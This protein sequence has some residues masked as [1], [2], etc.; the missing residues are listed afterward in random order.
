[1]QIKMIGALVALLM[2]T[3]FMPSTGAEHSEDPLDLQKAIEFAN[4]GDVITVH[5]DGS[6]TPLPTSAT[7]DKSGLTICRGAPVDGQTTVVQVH[8]EAT[9]EEVC[10]QGDDQPLPILDASGQGTTMLDIQA[11]GVTVRDL[12][13]RW[14]IDLPADAGTQGNPADLAEELTSTHLVGVNVAAGDVTL[15]RNEIRLKHGPCASAQIN[16]QSPIPAIGINLANGATD[17]SVVDN[18]VEVSLDTDDAAIGGSIG[19]HVAS[20]SYLI[21]GN[22][23]RYWAD[24]AIE[25]T[26]PTGTDVGQVATERIVRGNILDTNPVYGIEVH[27][28][29]ET[30][31]PVIEANTISF[32]TVAPVL[33]QEADEVVVRNNLIQYPLNTAGSGVW[34]R[35][36]EHVTLEDN[37]FKLFQDERGNQPPGAAVTVSSAPAV[38]DSGPVD[39]IVLRGNCFEQGKAGFEHVALKVSSDVQLSTIDARL[40]DWSVD[41]WDEVTARV[42]DQGATNTIQVLPFLTSS[43]ENCAE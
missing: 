32:T 10:E 27:D 38:A 25:I 43:S 7:V 21:E 37:A 14:T 42:L 41:T 29:D 8:H 13:L 22:T 1:M 6:S 24:S 5:A 19:I 16:C 15:E 3:A 11:D 34:L 2:V 17:A 4:P 36:A 20:T 33:L 31:A 12:E 9:A 35:G 30:T 39:D 23:L 18:T 40:N 28:T 26:P